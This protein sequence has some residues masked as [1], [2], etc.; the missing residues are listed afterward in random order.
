MLLLF[1]FSLTPPSHPLHYLSAVEEDLSPST[2][3]TLWVRIILCWGDGPVYSGMFSS[4][5]GLY[6][7]D[8]T[9][10]PLSCVNNK[11]SPDL[12][13]GST[14]AKMTPDREPLF[15]KSPAVNNGWG[16]LLGSNWILCQITFA[17]T[18]PHAVGFFCFLNAN[19]VAHLES[20]SSQTFTEHP[21]WLLPLLP[22]AAVYSGHYDTSQPCWER[23][24]ANAPG[25]H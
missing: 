2:P 12:A 21:L 22:R 3:L 19:L 1:C 14:G 10:T 9:S 6:P 23:R 13:K 18:N 4:P 7:L 20:F 5:H 17:Q 25:L 11:M 8:I 24:H 16:P 15:Y